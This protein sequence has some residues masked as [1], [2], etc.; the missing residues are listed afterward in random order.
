MSKINETCSGL[1]SGLISY[2][3]RGVC[4]YKIGEYEKAYDDFSTAIYYDP[5]CAEAYDKRAVCIIR[6][7]A[8]NK[9]LKENG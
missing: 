5:N 4:L 2:F 6:V 7:I 3:N 1:K 9:E 8:K